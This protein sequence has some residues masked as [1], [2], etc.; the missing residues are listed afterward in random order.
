M[1]VLN[2][3]NGGSQD[4]HLHRSMNDILSNMFDDEGKPTHTSREQASNN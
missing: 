4:P 2:G 1:D 3:G